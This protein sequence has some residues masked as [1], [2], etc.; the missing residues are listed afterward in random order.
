MDADD[1]LRD[2]PTIP[3]G[4][5]LYRRIHPNQI[6]DGRVS[7]AAFK[8]RTDPH[9]SVD[10]SS[11]CSPRET[12]ARHPGHAGVAQLLTGDARKV[13]N[14]VARAPTDDNP[15]HGLILDP[16]PQLSRTRVAKVLASAC[17]WVIPPA[18]N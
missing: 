12:L 17:T 16:R 1:E 6:T 15:A 18:G 10:L 7:S 2:D 5:L 11:L 4:E 9:P 14:G 3:D 8:S 13:T